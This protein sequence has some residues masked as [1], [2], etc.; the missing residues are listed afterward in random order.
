MGATA[1]SGRPSNHRIHGGINMKRTI[2]AAACAAALAGLAGCSSSDDDFQS[3]L[4]HAMWCDSQ[5]LSQ[6]QCRA[7]R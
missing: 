1:G 5:G 3:E 7:A 2:A 6:A 4:T